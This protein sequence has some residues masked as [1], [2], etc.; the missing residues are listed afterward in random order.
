MAIQ[1]QKKAAGDKAATGMPKTVAP[2]RRPAPDEVTAIRAPTHPGYGM[3][4]DT[5]RS[6]TSPGEL[7][8]S[9]LA[10]NLE[11]SADSENLLNQIRHGGNAELQSPQTRTVSAEPYP[12]AHGHHAPNA[13]PSGTVPA[14]F[15]ASASAPA[16]KP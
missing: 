1:I 13:S 11:D 16:R 7:V 2:V 14:K 3:N 9:P 8:Q 12:T 4:G 5:N 15:G 10:Q 6:S